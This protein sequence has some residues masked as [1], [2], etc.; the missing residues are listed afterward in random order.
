MTQPHYI[1]KI[2][3]KFNHYNCKPVSTP[4]D[5]NIRLYPNTSRSISQLKYARVIGCLIYVMTCTRPDIAFAIRKLSRYTN[6]PSQAHRQAV[7]IIL[8]YLKHKMD[9]GIYYT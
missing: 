8:K 7:Y 1:E 3:K 6:N 4:F 5:S 9:Y 2:L